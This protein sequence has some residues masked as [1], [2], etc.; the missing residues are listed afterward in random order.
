MAWLQD[1]YQYQNIFGPLVKME[2]DHDKAMREGQVTSKI[3]HTRYSL[4]KY[5]TSGTW[6][7][8]WY[9][10][11]VTAVRDWTCSLGSACGAAG[12]YP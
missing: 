11:C 3:H 10:N 4:S 6:H 1:A 5:I 9:L 8:G 12:V 2:A 7:A